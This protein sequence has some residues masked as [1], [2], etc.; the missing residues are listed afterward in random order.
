MEQERP[1]SVQRIPF[2]QHHSHTRQ[3]DLRYAADRHRVSRLVAPNDLVLRAYEAMDLGILVVSHDGLIS[4]YNS[5]Y[6]QLRHIPPDGLIGHPVA[7]L[8]RRES[9]RAFLETG[10]AQPDRPIDFDRRRNHETFIPLQEDGERLGCIVIVTPVERLAGVV[11]GARR[12]AGGKASSTPW[13]AQYSIVDIVGNSPTLVHAREL[14]LQAAQ[15]G[16]SVLLLGESGT[17]KELFAHAIHI[18]SPRYERPFVPVDCST[19]S[20]ELLEAELFGY[21]AGAFTGA[22]KEGKPGKFELA[23]G[24]TVFLDEIGEMPLE[25]QAKLLRVLQERRVVRVG[26]MAPIWVYFRIIASTNRYLE[27][28]VAQ[29]RFRHDLLYRL[30]VIR[31]DI[32]ALRERPEDI[33]LLLEHTLRRKSQ[34]LGIGATLSSQAIEVLTR[35]L[36]PGNIREMLNLVERLL[37]S[38][39]KRVIEPQDLP[40]YVKQG[41]TE[42]V[43][44]SSFSSFSSSLSLKAVVAEAERQALE[45]ALQHSHG[46][47]NLAAELV[48]LSRASFYRKLKEYGLTHDT[49]GSEVFHDL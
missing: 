12:R 46:N 35:Y 44:D 32:P 10:V 13:T 28:M 18:A 19:I 42:E 22:V 30:D 7:E 49:R 48:G 14:A 34:E 2:S 40:L 31:I 16:S 43:Q 20:R 6:A 27:S 33:P 5:M 25:M 21:A 41:L 38:V 8:D 29:K 37:V 4:H 15:V 17:G 9:I 47:R 24:G 45:K 23:D 39:R 3:N 11:P 36:W 1:G 26:G